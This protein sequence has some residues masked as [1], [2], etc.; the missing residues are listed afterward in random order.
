[1]SEL[2]AIETA[3]HKAIKISTERKTEITLFSHL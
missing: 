2:H 3:E 1:M